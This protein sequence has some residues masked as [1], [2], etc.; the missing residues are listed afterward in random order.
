MCSKQATREILVSAFSTTHRLKYN[1]N[2]MYGGKN[3]PKAE[4]LTY[5]NE[6]GV[7]LTL[8]PQKMEESAL[9]ALCQCQMSKY[10]CILS[11]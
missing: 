2:K 6:S 1:V 9:T 4:N 5:A 10:E 7:V 11:G 3:L 8:P